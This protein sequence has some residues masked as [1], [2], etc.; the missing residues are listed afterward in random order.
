MENECF[1]LP[2]GGMIVGIVIGVIIILVGLS[3]FLQATYGIKIDFWPF[4]LIIFGVLI[5]LGALFRQ[6]R[7]SG[8]SSNPP[9]P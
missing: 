8:R 1:G 2:N 4:I 5:L 6:R 3:L 7:Y 9:P